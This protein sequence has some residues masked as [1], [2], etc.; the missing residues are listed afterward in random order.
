MSKE[1]EKPI[2]SSAC[3][4]TEEEGKVSYGSKQKDMNVYWM[5]EDK[6]AP[7]INFIAV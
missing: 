2:E 5:P 3:L 4:V 1:N 7:I 6:Y